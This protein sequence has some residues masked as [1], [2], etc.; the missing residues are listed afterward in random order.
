MRSTAGVTFL[1]TADI[2]GP[3]TNEELVGRALAGRRAT[4]DSSPPSSASCAIRP[5]PQRR[6]IDGSP[7]TCARPARR[8]A[9]SGRRAHRPLLPAP[10][11]SQGADRG[12]G[13][14]H[15]RAGARG[16]GALPRA[17]GGVAADDRARA[18]ACT[19]SRR[20]RASTRCGRATPRTACCD[21]CGE[22]GIGFV[23]YSPLGRGFLTGAI[24]TPMT[25]RRTTTAARNPGSRARTSPRN[26]AL[27]DKVKELAA[28]KGCTAGAA[29][30]RL[31][32][33]AGATHRA[34]PG[35]E[36][37]REPGGESRRAGGRLS[38]D[39]L[40]AIEAVF[41]AGAFAGAR[42]PEGMMRLVRG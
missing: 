13:G 2:Y 23:P 30:A 32:A 1:D 34:D 14:R 7:R 38:D 28:D 41:P 40:A 33:G 17:V 25:S 6:A 5:T 21:A 39:E 3:Y 35:H 10:R 20:C 37:Q 12:D 36:R 9:A 15:G 18:R 42:Y 26:L 31:G 22:L 16:Q 29:G 27:V 24:K 19:A 8:P 4:G 11:R